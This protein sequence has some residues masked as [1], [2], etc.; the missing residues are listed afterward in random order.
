MRPLHER[1]PVILDPASDGVWIDPT[2]SA[3]ALRSLFVPFASERMEAFPVGSW[4]S[5]ARNEGPRC[6]EPA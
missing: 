5:N 3:D 6:L 4:V 1:K 2:S